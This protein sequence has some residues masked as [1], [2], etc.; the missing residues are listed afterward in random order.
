M[1]PPLS[2]SPVDHFE[3]NARSE[4]D[5]ARN[6]LEERLKQFE[7]EAQ[8][9]MQALAIAEAQAKELEVK[10]EQAQ[11]EAKVSQPRQSVLLSC[12]L[13]L[14]LLCRCAKACGPR[15]N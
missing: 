11:T 2:R 4:A 7:T 15:P 9:A 12:P 1:C 8:R 6:D 13:T 10:V 14:I 3:Q 5:K